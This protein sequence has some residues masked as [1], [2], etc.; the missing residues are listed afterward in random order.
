MALYAMIF[1]LIFLSTP[2]ARRATLSAQ[3][4]AASRWRIS[5]HALRE[6]GDAAG[7]CRPRTYHRF[8]STPSA[9]RATRIG[10]PPVFESK[11]SIHA[12]REEGDI[13]V[14]L[15]TGIF[16][17]FLST[18]SAR[19]ATLHDRQQE[20]QNQ[21]FY[22]RPP[23]GGRLGAIGV[24]FRD[25]L[26]LST[27]SARRATLWD[28]LRQL[29][30]TISIHALREEGDIL[31][32]LDKIYHA[33]FLSTPS[34]RRATDYGNNTA[35]I[36]EFLST[37]SARR[38]TIRCR[39]EPMPRC[40]FY[41][42]PPRGGRR[43]TSPDARLDRSISIHALREEGDACRALIRSKGVQ[44]LSTPSARRATHTMDDVKVL[45]DISI[46]ALREEGDRLTC[47][48]LPLTR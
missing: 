9:R 26:F 7:C 38:A 43:V 8:L 28:R 41:P 15:G 46:H 21:H 1:S 37:P 4:G 18:P 2:S 3:D 32:M 12:L 11:I 13:W 20:R 39:S 10:R 40:D 24:L 27:P 19:R 31:A 47:P 48:T 6:E 42:R 45:H 36:V 16:A 44:F 30:I 35:Q 23:R 34:A 25:F 29:R 17:K 33:L 14:E 5:I 22:P